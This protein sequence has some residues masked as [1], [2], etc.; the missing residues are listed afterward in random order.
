MSLS[1]NF[2]GDFNGLLATITET[3]NNLP[4]QNALTILCRQKLNE[5]FF[6]GIL[7]QKETIEQLLTKI[8]PL[9]AKV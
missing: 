8:N 6:A 4:F 2:N 5:L 9:L 7:E 1:I 3:E